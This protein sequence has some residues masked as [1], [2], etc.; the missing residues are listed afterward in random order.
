[1]K[2]TQLKYLF[3]FLLAFSV[4]NACE[5]DADDPTSVFVGDY[6]ITEALVAEEFDLTTI[7]TGTTYQGDTITVP[8]ETNIT[9]SI[10]VALLGSIECTPDKSL[11]ELR[12]DNSMYLSCDGTTVELD[13]GTW[14]EVDEATIIL[15]MNAAAVPSSVVGFSLTVSNITLVGSTLSG[16]TAVPLPGEMLAPLVTQYS[17]GALALDLTANPI[18]YVKLKLTLT[19]Q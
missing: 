15:N 6:L 1:M 2:K 19:K 10:Q 4:F 12:K 9:E 16:E 13:A 5:D 3:L 11:I 8:A 7:V 17:Q 14:E 18:V